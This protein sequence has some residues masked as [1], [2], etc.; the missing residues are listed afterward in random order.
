[1]G[2]LGVLT[3]IP[4]THRLRVVGAPANSESSG[5]LAGLFA[6]LLFLFFHRKHSVEA[7]LKLSAGSAYRKDQ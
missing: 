5:L 1:M 2:F 6:S 4:S 7:V 3:T